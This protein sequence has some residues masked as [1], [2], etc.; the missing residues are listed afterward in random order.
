MRCIVHLGFLGVFLAVLLLLVNLSSVFEFTFLAFCACFLY[1]L[2]FFVLL[3]LRLK[4]GGGE[5]KIRKG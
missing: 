1:G 3:G 2:A 4:L 5:E